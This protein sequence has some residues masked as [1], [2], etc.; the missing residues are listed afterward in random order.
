M[1]SQH[2]TLHKTN[3]VKGH[4]LFGSTFEFLTNPVAYL[5]KLAKDYGPFA[6]VRFAGKKYYIL[7]HPDYVKHV[8]LANHKLYRKPGATKLLSIFLGEGLSTSNGEL[9]LRQR[10]LMQ[11]AFYSERM[12]YFTKVIDEEVIVFINKLNK[13]PA[14]TAIE[15][16]REFLQ[17]TIRI[18]SRCMF[19]IGFDE[20]IKTLVNTL[21]E[22]AAFAAAWMK[23]AVKLPTSLPTTA[24]RKFRKNCGVFDKIIYKII[25]KRRI[26]LANEL[27]RSNKDLLDLLLSFSDEETKTPL[28][29]KLL[30]DEVTTIFMAGHETTAQTLSWMLYH[31]AKEKT[32][33][34]KVK[35][36]NEKVCNN[37]GFSF[38]DIPKLTYT[39]QVIQETLRLYPPI[40]AVMRKPIH[41]DIIGEL[42]LPAQSNLLLN[43]YGLHQHQDYW[44]YPE[45]FYP[46]HFSEASVKA[47]PG[48][49]YVPF[50]GG[51]RL[52]IGQNFAMLVMH[53]VIGRLSQSFEFSVPRNYIPTVEPNITLR[54][55]G[56]IQLIINKVGTGSGLPAEAIN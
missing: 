30:R 5:T 56:G 19:T 44:Q 14:N 7:Q 53:I 45:Q 22:L 32:I 50:G 9:W 15:V 31:L 1:P 17:L 4:F 28:S 52:C 21:E 16:S 51:P 48:F 38:E 34:D 11:P 42:H 20:E 3:E 8:W 33:N 23:N 54:A 26:E 35:K 40:W 10:R 37:G 36:E 27:G 29:E 24:N 49:V 41:H 55:K 46:E 2:N 25:E 43:I 39:K 6:I 18:I 13:I 47:R 12:Q